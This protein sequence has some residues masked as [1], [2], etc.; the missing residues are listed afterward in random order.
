MFT[1]ERATLELECRTALNK[2]TGQGVIDAQWYIDGLEADRAT[3]DHY[4]ILVDWV[5]IVKGVPTSV[6]VLRRVNNVQES[7]VS[8][9]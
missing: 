3:I 9:L 8:E 1:A 5:T 6:K 2:T 7:P 4:N